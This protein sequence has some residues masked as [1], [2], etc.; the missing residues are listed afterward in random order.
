MIKKITFLHLSILFLFIFSTNLLA[1]TQAEMNQTAIDNF[2]KAD[3]E[4][5][6]VYKKLV[7]KL[8][9]KEKNLLI[10]AQKNWIKFRD[11][12]CEFEKQQYDGG[13]IQPLIYYT[14]L[15]EC[16]EDRTEDLKRNL[17]DRNR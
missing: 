4:L 2:T 3:N 1:Q 13:S 15:A 7:K 11:A 17:E 14:C 12:K 6:Q 8:D 16:T 10:T 5:N 9:E